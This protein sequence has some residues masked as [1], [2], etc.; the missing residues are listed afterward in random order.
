MLLYSLLVYCTYWYD[1]MSLK[2]HKLNT[3]APLLVPGVSSGL[4]GNTV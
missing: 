1:E 4:K 2:S 3:F